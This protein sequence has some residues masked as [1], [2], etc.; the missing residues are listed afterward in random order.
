MLEERLAYLKR[1]SQTLDKVNEPAETKKATVH[2]QNIQSSRISYAS[3]CVTDNYFVLPLLNKVH[4]KTLT[5]QTYTLNKAH[6][7]ALAQ[8]IPKAEDVS[9]LRFEN[10][11]IEDAEFALILAACSQLKDFKSIVYVRNQLGEKSIDSIH[12]LLEKRI[13]NHL[14]EVKV[15]DCRMTLPV[16][17]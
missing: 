1:Q 16:S 3:T 9:K 4:N 12:G 17:A 5:L 14:E 10:C 8:A 15:V 6:C 2:L 11:G 7:K 13:P